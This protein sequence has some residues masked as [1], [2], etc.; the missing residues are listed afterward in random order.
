MLV[1]ASTMSCGCR[2]AFVRLPACDGLALVLLIEALGKG[3]A[4]TATPAK[5]MEHGDVRA[6]VWA[7]EIDTE[8]VERMA[9][10]H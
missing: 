9:W 7:E 6:T 2:Q 8:P 3:M 4:I 1:R 10:G 5:C